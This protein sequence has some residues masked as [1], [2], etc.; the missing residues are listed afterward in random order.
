MRR[1]PA[2][3]APLVAAV[4]ALAWSA[5]GARSAPA[6]AYSLQVVP[7]LDVNG[8]VLG[9]EVWLAE[10]AWVAYLGGGWE[11]P[12]PTD[13]QGASRAGIRG[14]LG[15]AIPVSDADTV[16]L[17]AAHWPVSWVPGWDGTSGLLTAWQHSAAGGPA[18]RVGAVVAEVWARR[19]GKATVR[20]LVGAVGT[21][22]ELA[23]QL[24][25]RPTLEGVVGTGVAEAGG[26][27]PLFGAVSAS[28]AFAAA[29]FR[30]EARAAAAWPPE[31]ALV[32]SGVPAAP[33]TAGRLGFR[34]GGWPAEFYVRAAAPAGDQP[35]GQAALGLSVERRYEFGELPALLRWWPDARGYGALF[36]DAA[37]KGADFSFA[38]EAV[39]AAGAGVAA[40]LASR[41]VGELEAFLG[42]SSGPAVRLGA[43][44]R[45]GV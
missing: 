40:G 2:W 34:V 20:A 25:A 35:P 29:G 8:P 7:I 41:A 23:P 11:L 19:E 14:R 1:R 27:R 36:A 9:G 45:A 16:D 42:V 37:V 24:V 26:G 3:A 39:S 12:D 28:L 38:R 43:R 6:G 30:I 15:L 4:A 33:G 44:I 21:E 18:W 5:P 17:R 32:P 10:E 13:P 31:G 22:W